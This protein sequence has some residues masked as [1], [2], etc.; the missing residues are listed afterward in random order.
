[1]TGPISATNYTNHAN[2]HERNGWSFVTIRVIR[3]IRGKRS[4]TFRFQ[5]LILPSAF[6]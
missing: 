5:A 2:D 6:E 3:V 4:I 1:M